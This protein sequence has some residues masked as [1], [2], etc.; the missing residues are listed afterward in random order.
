[1]PTNLVC[2]KDPIAQSEHIFPV[3]EEPKARPKK[4]HV[5]DNEGDLMLSFPR[6]ASDEL[7]LLRLL[8]IEQ[9]KRVELIALWAVH[10]LAHFLDI[11]ALG[12]LQSSQT[13]QIGAGRFMLFAW[14]R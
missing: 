3:F 8:P 4:Y 6:D 1:M 14:M 13:R 2:Y 12:K 5:S 10:Y 7:I 11:D 9:L